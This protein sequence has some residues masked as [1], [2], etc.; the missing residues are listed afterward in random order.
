MSSQ[1]PAPF[2]GSY[3]PGDVQ[4]L[5]AP[6]QLEM[7]PV[8]EKE[9]LI[10]SGQKHY[11]EMLSQEPAPSPAHLAL[12]SQALTA[13]A[14]RM[15]REVAALAKGLIEQLGQQPI[16]LVSLV[17]AGVPLGVMLQ[18]A[19]TE[20]RHEAYHYGISIIRDR[21]IDEAAINL[22]EAR[23]G[24]AGIVFVDGWTGK[25]AI[26]AQLTASL[27]ERQGYPAIPRL[28]VLADPAGCAWLAASEDD[29]LIP[30]GI[31]GAPV[32]GMVSRSV[33]T[34]SGFHGCVRCE[35]LREYECSTRLVDTVDRFRR[36]LLPEAVAPAQPF[37]TRRSE[38]RSRSRLVLDK[39]ATRFGIDNL[40]RIKPGIAEATRAVLRRVPDYV[41]VRNKA[42]PDVLLLVRLA[43]Q[44]GLDIQEVGEEI[45]PYRAVTIIKK[46]A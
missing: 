34:E 23:H 9:Q 45:G 38:Q 31:M 33:W 35:H 41:L 30:F 39:L 32:S 22:I 7:T 10:Q 2:H 40:N 28:V 16:V 24:T 25:G 44:K 11:S 15:A 13:G 14:P 3:L 17:R 20:L 29:W 43:E 42:D 5:L 21:G 26:T 12:F 8:A 1:H 4:F 37:A 6:L 27:H 19:L 18:R 46:V 36:E